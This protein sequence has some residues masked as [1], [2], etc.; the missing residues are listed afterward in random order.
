VSRV[1]VLNG[2]QIVA[3]AQGKGF[4]WSVNNALNN[5]T[6]PRIPYLVGVY[7]NIS[8]AVPDYAAALSNGG[9]DPH[10]HIY[11]AKKGEILDIAIQN[12]A[13]P[14]SGMVESHPWHAH[15]AKYWDM[16]A[17]LGNFS[18]A[19]LNQSRSEAKGQPFQ[20][21]TSVAFPGPGDSFNSSMIADDA[22]GG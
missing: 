2:Q 16:G 15:G 3:G 12:R 18:Y 20:R 11:P 5:G 14:T 13:G 22:P 8:M 6:T 10:S 1:V 7:S 9:F 21:D 19:S 4:R 17:G